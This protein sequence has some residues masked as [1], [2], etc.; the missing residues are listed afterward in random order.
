MT[1]A[2]LGLGSNLGDKAG[3]LETAIALLDAHADIRILRRSAFYLT[4]PWGDAAQ[5]FFV[6]ACVLAETSLQA[7]DLLRHCLGVEARMGRDREAA[8]RWGPRLIDI[9]I[10][11]FGEEAISAPGLTVPHPRLAERAFA[12]VP[13]AE[14]APERMIGGRTVAA[15]VRDLDRSGVEVWRG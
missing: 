15:L 2:A 1:E 8:R 4:E 9:D 5:D 13:L 6:N 10:L 3:N 14:I 7:G 11:L 12:L